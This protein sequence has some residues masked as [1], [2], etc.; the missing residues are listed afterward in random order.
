M[1]FENLGTIYIPELN[2]YGWVTGQKMNW[3]TAKTYC[4][5]HKPG[6]YLP[7]LEELSAVYPYKSMFD[8]T[9]GWFCSSTEKES[10]Y[11]YFINYFS[12]S[13]GYFK[14]P[15]MNTTIFCVG[16]P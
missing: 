15:N 11:A 10:E 1:F 9:E 12:G 8:V 16:N 14:K 3:D 2:K 4:Q 5:E 7:D 13:Q 6:M